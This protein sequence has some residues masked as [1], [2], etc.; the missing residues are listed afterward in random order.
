[1]SDSQDTPN[2]TGKDAGRHTPQDT[3]AAPHDAERDTASAETPRVRPASAPVDA[4]DMADISRVMVTKAKDGDTRAA[5][6][7]RKTWRWP[8]QAVRLA[9]PPVTGAASLAEA[10]AAVI[11]TARRARRSI[12]R[13]CWNTAGARSRPS[14]SSGRSR[15]SMPS[16]ARLPRTR[17]VGAS[18]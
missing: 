16:G 3:A 9:L 14:R 1:M 5:E 6:V 11:A 15:S 10:H 8:Q 2:D 4:A 7:A 12:S 17:S 18:D 13:P